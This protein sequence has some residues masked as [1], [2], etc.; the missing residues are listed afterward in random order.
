[1]RF[2]FSPLYL[3]FEEIDQA[4]AALADVLRTRSWDAPR[5]TERRRVT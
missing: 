4:A 3:R 1:M 2:G 5:F